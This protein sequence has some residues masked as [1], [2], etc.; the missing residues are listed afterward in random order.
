MVRPSTIVASFTLC[1]YL[2]ESLE[3]WRT[4]DR[5]SYGCKTIISVIFQLRLQNYSNRIGDPC[6]VVI[7]RILPLHNVSDRAF[8][9]LD[10]RK[11][12]INSSRLISP[13]SSKYKAFRILVWR[14]SLTAM[15]ALTKDSSLAYTRAEHQE[16]FVGPHRLTTL[17]T[18]PWWKFGGR[19]RSFV[20]TRSE[21]SK[22]SLDAFNDPGTADGDNTA[23]ESVFNDVKTFDI[24][25]PIEQYEGRH[26]FD[27]RATWSDAEE[28][29]LI[30]RVR[31]SLAH[32]LHT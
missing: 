8:L 25:K 31:T 26:R 2:F 16:S 14:L 28:K 5:G 3:L 7:D 24:Y 22:S 11:I 17:E 20:P 12:C 9:L 1:T 23:D 18:N 15:A 27:Q 30:R 4:H 10:E 32:T 29:K 6:Y 21:T 13:Q 19:D